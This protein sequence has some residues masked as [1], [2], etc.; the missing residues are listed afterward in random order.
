[1]AKV[2]ASTNPQQPRMTS[3]MSSPIMA[4]RNDAP[5]EENKETIK[6]RP[7][8]DPNLNLYQVHLCNHIVHL[9]CLKLSI[10]SKIQKPRCPV[11]DCRT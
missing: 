7:K 10:A 5:V 11:D 2:K 8:G 3:F 6:I 1:M 9:G 4:R